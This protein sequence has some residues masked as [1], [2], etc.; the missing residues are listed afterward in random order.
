[1]AKTVTP[2]S[3]RDILKDTDI[4]EENQNPENLENSTSLPSEG[5]EAGSISSTAFENYIPLKALMEFTQNF[6]F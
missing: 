1:M 3:I 5:S 2:F 4:F 6:K